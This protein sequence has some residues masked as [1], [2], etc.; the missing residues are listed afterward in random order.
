ME[1]FVRYIS[2]AGESVDYFV[3]SLPCL[4]TK[5]ITDFID[6]GEGWQWS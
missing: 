3:I 2:N 1:S 5:L 6:M 4:P